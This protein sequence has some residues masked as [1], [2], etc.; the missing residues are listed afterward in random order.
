[1]LTRRF[2]KM[3]GCLGRGTKFEIRGTK[4]AFEHHKH[5]LAGADWWIVVHLST[6]CD[7][8]RVSLHRY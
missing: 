7:L 6:R 4:A 3:N 1:M 8:L 2:L 5:R